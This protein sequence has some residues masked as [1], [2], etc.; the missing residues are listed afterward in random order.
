MSALFDNKR[1]VI[2]NKYICQIPRYRDAHAAFHIRKG[3]AEIKYID[4]K[5][6]F[7]TTEKQNA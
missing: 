1:C 6:F 5:Q 2:C 4:H 7:V 3:E